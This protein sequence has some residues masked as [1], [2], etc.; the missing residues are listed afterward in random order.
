[1]LTDINVDMMNEIV[2]T[3][4]LVWSLWSDA[5][6]GDCHLYPADRLRKC[7]MMCH[8]GGK[9]PRTVVLCST[10][11][12][13]LGPLFGVP[14][15]AA[16][17][18]PLSMEF[19]SFSGR[20]TGVGCHFLLH[21]V[22][23]FR[24]WT[25]VSCICHIVRQILYHQVAWETPGNWCC[26]PW[27]GPA[28]YLLLEVQCAK[29]FIFTLNNCRWFIIYVQTFGGALFMSCD[30]HPIFWDSLSS[31]WLWLTWLNEFFFF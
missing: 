31:N 10:M 30:K 16:Y 20:N 17:Q 28:G 6:D 4:D 18:A 21:R 29:W 24:D 2:L 27:N 15:T 1:M 5:V 7:D 13:S 22:F 9:K 25:H 26:T 14:W 23:L 11:S 12:S 3:D 19:F 8:E